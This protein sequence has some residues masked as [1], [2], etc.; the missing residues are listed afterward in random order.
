M[1]Y[2]TTTLLAALIIG[3]GPVLACDGLG[4]NMHMGNIVSIDRGSNTFVILD[5]QS[6]KPIRFTAAKETLTPFTVNDMV[7]VGYEVI[8]GGKLR[9]VSLV[10]L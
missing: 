9:S 3:A 10:R 1:K 2:A 7:E 4:E 5:A 8:D 6:Q